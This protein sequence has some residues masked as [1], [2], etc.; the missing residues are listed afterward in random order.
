[1]LGQGHLLG[2]QPERGGLLGEL[3]GSE[4]HRQPLLDGW[5]QI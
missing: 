1:M 2:A 5:P 3:R 4:V